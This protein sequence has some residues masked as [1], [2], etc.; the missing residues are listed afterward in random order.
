[1]AYKWWAFAVVSV[2]MFLGAMESSGIVVALPEFGRLFAAGPE[3]VL[4]VVLAYTL[5]LTGFLLTAG[6]IADVV[7]RKRVYMAGFL[8]FTLALA[9]STLA[10]ELWQLVACRVLQGLGGAMLISNGNAIITAAFPDD[11]RGKALGLA[12]SV[13][14]AGLMLG[15]IAA[16]F[17]LD[18]LDWRAIFYA[19]IPIGLVGL[20][21]AWA[22]LRET[23]RPLGRVRFDV[24]GALTLFGGLVCLMI[25]INQGHR[26]GW[27]SPALLALGAA[28]IALLALFLAIE[29][30]T[31]DPV[32]DLRLFRNRAFSA[33]SAVLLAYFIPYPAIPLV[34]PYYLVQGLAYT[35][36]AVGLFLAVIPIL[37]FLLSPTVGT[38]SDRHGPWP[39]TTVGL[40]LQAGGLFLISRLGADA[41]GIQ[42]VVALGVMGLG[43]GLFLTPTYS[44]V[45]GGV[46]PERIGT[47]SAL[48]ATLRSIGM[49]TGQ[50]MAT[51]I[52][53]VRRDFH[54]LALAGSLDGV[55]RGR[56]SLILGFQD[57]V[58]ALGSIAVVG[59]AIA[60]LFARPKPQ[61][62]GLPGLAQ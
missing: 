22:V 43:A 20:V 27:G 56:Q 55:E 13:V 54:E 5:T 15:P 17:L 24:G 23:A 58:L 4:W 45:M 2:G 59:V 6:R 32:I 52:F 9:L 14:G 62:H 57:A 38:L 1:M 16:G 19:R 33:F 28:A 61:R 10:Q 44:A 18:L 51:A 60:I 7:G 53:A 34:L 31:P 11:E 48:I 36:S 26:L 46:P 39:L 50:A 3:T 8:V 12:E 49:S 37:M 21:L 25:A 40:A 30:R 41:S 47:A 42:V 29:A 35:A